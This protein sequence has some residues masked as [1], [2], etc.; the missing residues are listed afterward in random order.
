MSVIRVGSTSK[1]ADGWDHIFSGGKK[2]ATKA[3]ATPK[4]AKK[5]AAPAGTK[6]AGKK[7]GKKR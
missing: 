7:A 1:Y 6:K 2:P 5:A 3:A 4:A